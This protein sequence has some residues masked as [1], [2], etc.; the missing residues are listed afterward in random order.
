MAGTGQN[1]GMPQ[2]NEGAAA[3]LTEYAELLLMTE[4]NGTKR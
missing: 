2:A 1:S 3:L 4:G